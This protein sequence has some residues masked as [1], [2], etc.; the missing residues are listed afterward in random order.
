MATAVK[1]VKSIPG[2]EVRDA[3]IRIRISMRGTSV[4]QRLNA[5]DGSALLP[6]AL[7]VLYATQLVTKIK[8]D[9]KLG[10]YEHENYFATESSTSETKPIPTLIEQ[11]D[12]WFNTLD[13]AK[14]TMRGY[15]V[16]CNFWRRTTIEIT[17]G[18][19]KKARVEE[20]KIADIAL[21]KLT[22]S[23]LQLARKK[24][25]ELS[26]KTFNN[27]LSAVSSALALAVQD[28]IITEAVSTASAHKKW[29][30]KKPDPFSIPEISSIVAHMRE[31]YD[32]RIANLVEFWSL[33]GLRSSEIYGLRWGSVDFNLAEIKVHE[34][35]V[36]GE[37]KSSTKTES[38][39]MVLLT[40]R[41]IELLKLQKKFTF[42]AGND[43]FV[44]TNPYDELPWH[45]E[46]SIRNKYWIPTLR[47]L[48][49]RY[50]RP[51]NMR[52]TNATMRLMSGQK[53]GYAA[54]QMGHS[55]EMFTRTYARWLD[56]EQDRIELEKFERLTAA[57]HGQEQ[58]AGYV[59]HAR[60]IA[61][62]QAKR[63]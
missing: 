37:H 32:E 45:S 46:K 35:L 54:V 50:R 18:R 5:P 20:V 7:N 33:T 44:F 53:I 10:T 14:S 2:V 39:R 23:H 25:S 57:Q 63:P 52:H 59:R 17:V 6:T 29:Q 31:R 12:H 30:K 36:R 56:G 49:I 41:A 22:L 38:S 13:L 1:K 15:A 27:Y 26:G 43:A 9:I 51:Y 4:I 34:A 58:A 8:A 24:A 3:S 42:M 21:D 47:A 62:P 28:G 55:I 48:G 11:I 16:C 40:K 60:G 19:G 61:G